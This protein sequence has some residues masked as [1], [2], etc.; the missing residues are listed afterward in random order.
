MAAQKRRDEGSIYEYPEGSGKWFA[1]EHIGGKLV[2]RRAASRQAAKEKLKELQELK[3]EG[4]DLTTGAQAVR[5]WMGTFLE[6]KV[7]LGGLDIRSQNFNL[8]MIERYI[9]PR[10]GDMR[11]CDVRSPHL[12]NVIDL[13]FA[14]IQAGGR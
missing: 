5:T 13:T 14:E 12:Q 8:D 7:R 6:Q 1:Q 9:T 2:R 11:T 3:K 4:V 10:I